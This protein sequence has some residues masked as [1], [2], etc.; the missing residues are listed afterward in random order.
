MLH[1]T[2]VTVPV[3]TPGPGGDGMPAA[4]YHPATEG[5][6]GIVLVQEIFGR[7]E[8]LRGRASDLADLGYTVV[9]PQIYWRL[10][11]DV[12]PEASE[13][14]LMTGMGAVT[15]LDWPLAVADVRDTVAWLR[16]ELAGEEGVALVGFC[17]GGGLAFAAVQDASGPG[18]A[19]ALVSYYG[20]AL[21][22]LVDGPAVDV[23][24]LHHFGDADAFIPA[25]DRARIQ[26]VVEADGAEF[27]LWEGANHAF[28]NH[29]ASWHH[30]Q[31]AREAWEVTVEW[32][33]EHHPY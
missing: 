29:L 2:D 23:P 18:R 13:D 8:Y 17:F 6:A 33:A 12:I 30:P 14:S 21:P 20:S 26:E 15:A 27:H 10:G 16:G 19:D 22:G 28:D 11:L 9:V 31:A 4:V 32:L 1:T 24:S 5:G 3:G 25:D 7:S